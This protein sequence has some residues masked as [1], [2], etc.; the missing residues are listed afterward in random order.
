V[1]GFRQ[2]LRDGLRRLLRRP[3][4]TLVGIGTLALGLSTS[5]AVFTYVNAYSR[6]LPGAH[7]DGLHQVWLSTEDRPWGALSLPDFEDLLEL[8]GDGI[9][10]TGVGASF[11][12]ASVRHQQLAE[13]AVGE[14]VTGAFFSIL[15]IEMSAGR[16][17]APDDDRPGA[18]PVAILSHD[19]WVSRYGADP[20]AIGR[21]I[22]LNGEPY[23]I[24]GVASPE[25]RGTSSG[26][27][28][29]FWIPLEQ[30]V[31]V[32]LAR[33]DARVDRESSTVLPIVRLDEGT[34]VA[35]AR[36]ALAGLASGLDREVPLADRT[37]RFTLGP[38]TWIGPET[39]D[40]ESATTRIL[41]AAAAF[42]LLL[43][44]ANVANLVL[45]AGARRHAEIAIRGALGAS[46]PRLVRQ[47]LTESLLLS[48]P[49][50]VV[51]M[52]LAGPVSQR[53]S[54]YFASPSVWG[55][56]VAREIEVDP[57]V[58]LFAIAAAVLTGAAAGLV[59]ALRAS[60]RSPAEALGTRG[61]GASGRGMPRG[62]LPGTRDLLVSAQI[63]ICV[64]L[65]FVA[66]LV[67]RTLD[68]A[69]GVD[70]GFDTTATLASYV[71]TSSIGTPI[72]ERHAF[73]EELIRHFELLSWVEGATIAENAPLSGHPVERIDPQDGTE[74]I[75]ATVARVWPGYFELLDIQLVRGRMFAR[76]DTVGG[77]AVVVVN[78]TLAARLAPDSD[79]IGRTLMAAA[80][81]GEPDAPFEVVGVVRDSRLVT[82]LDAPGP[83]AYF[84]LPQQYSRPG[85]ALVLKVRGDPWTA[86]EMTERELRAVDTRLAIV[87]ILP[88]RDVVSG[89]LYAQRM[90]AE[91]FTAIGALGLLLSAAGVFAVL[92]LAI[93]GRRRE[94]GIRMAVGADGVSIA[95]AV[96]GPVG[97]SVLLG[98]GVG[99]VGAL[100]ATRV[101][102]SLLWGVEPTDPIALGLGLLTLLFAVA[103]A[104]WVPLRRA[105]RVDPVQSLR[106]E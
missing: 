18:P 23:D 14:T 40:A 29:Q 16:G 41:M 89:A 69:R 64:V 96:L 55:T 60:E 33:S 6:P 3:G 17:F 105:L 95:R 62:W 90:N 74:P 21:A 44:C 27:R 83:V 101:V 30:Y 19:Y 35:S 8:D 80:G 4:F 103:G 85:N 71:S 75:S 106:S 9:S 86:T 5:T 48:V 15:G 52:I 39:R 58:L 11:F 56:N 46:R 93:S 70:P 67:L 43:A 65:V 12:A 37:R 61:T 88:Y 53:L 98:L 20:D 32:Y 100:A 68:S 66:G 26:S 79:A 7:A 92:A 76:T 36:D 24:V 99:L 42:L 82:L 54:S 73:F 87:N 57:Q 50:G 59:P 47:L 49:A 97:G 10:V 84:S 63:A 104:S 78:E 77:T 72:E 91:L 51:A 102:E 22:I 1:D 45:S 2:D 25:F 34:S 28:P 13:V 31:R 81:L 94:I 38:I